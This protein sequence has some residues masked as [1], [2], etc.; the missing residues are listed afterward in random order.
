[1]LFQQTV[2]HILYIDLVLPPYKY[3]EYF[4]FHNFQYY[5]FSQDF[6]TPEY[7]H[8]FEFLDYFRIC[9]YDCNWCQEYIPHFECFDYLD[10][11]HKY[12]YVHNFGI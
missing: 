11:I 4:H 6:D 8:N 7:Y 9:E 12:E 1:M 3:I 10:Y 2:F 5:S